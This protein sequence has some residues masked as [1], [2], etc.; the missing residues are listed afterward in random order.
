[1][2]DQLPDDAQ[3]RYQEWLSEMGRMP[4]RKESFSRGYHEA[5]RLIREYIEAA[6]TNDGISA[7]DMVAHIAEMVGAGEPAD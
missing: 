2:T 7:A 1:M 3:K 5:L 4:H 6:R